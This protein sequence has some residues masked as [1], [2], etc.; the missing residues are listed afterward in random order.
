[1]SALAEANRGPSMPYGNDDWTRRVERS[2]A[3]IFEREVRAFPVATGTAANALVARDAG[4]ALRLDLRARGSAR[5]GRRVRRAGTVQRRRQ[6]ASG[7]GRARQADAP[8]CWRVRSKRGQQQRRPPGDPRRH[9]PHP[10]DGGG[11]GLQAG[12]DAGDRR[13]GAPAQGAPAHGRRA[14]RQRDGVSR[15]AGAAGD[16]GGGHRRPLVRRQQGRLHGGG[17]GGVLRPRVG[18]E[19]RPPPHAR[20]GTSFPRC[21]SSRPSSKPISPTACG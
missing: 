8:R 11:H 6:A 1:M 14:L 15:R 10:G 2:C 18:R 9:Q 5:H 16:L 12:G 17:G 13:G 20:P 21:A 4:A 19:L 3:E 7:A